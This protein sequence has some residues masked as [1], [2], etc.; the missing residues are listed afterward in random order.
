MYKVY[1]IQI[2]ENEY[3][4]DI[5]TM[6]N[7]LYNVALYNVRQH[8][9]NHKTYLNY[10]N[11]YP[12][13]KENENYK[14]MPSQAA[15]QVIKQVDSS[16]KSF[17]Q[18]LKDYKKHPNK[19]KSCP[20]IPKYKEKGSKSVVTIPSQ[21]IY[22]KDNYIQFPKTKFKLFLGE[23]KIDKIV[24]VKIKPYNKYYEI[25]I[26]YEQEDL[27]HVKKNE[28][29]IGIDLGVN[30]FITVSNNIGKRPFIVK[31]GIIKSMNQYYN[32]KKAELMSFIGDKGISNRIHKLS[33]KRNNKIMFYLHN[34]SRH[35]INYC[36]DNNISNI[37]IGYNKEWKQEVK[38]GYKKEIIKQN[39]QNFVSIPFNTLI[40]Q[41]Q[42]KAEQVGIT[43]ILNEE[44]HTSK[45]DALA[46]EDIKHKEQYFGKRVHRGLYKSRTNEIIN[47][48]VNGSLNI[49]RKVIGNDF[50]SLLNRGLVKNPFIV[51]YDKEFVY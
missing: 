2:K 8:F 3:L 32:K 48:D 31:G 49:L 18:A 13:C 14:G 11:N 44:S 30:N 17:F 24:E 26:T 19:Y 21:T 40:Q 7:N 25:C 50:I 23:L 22:R 29:Y 43:V 34:V 46:L 1:K 28:N 12:I 51:K 27:K 47:A 6:S 5:T 35:L 20:K 38:I 4:K 41:I 16:F 15:Q 9:F 42:Y 39:N 33:R 45:C 37:V 36:I 10:F